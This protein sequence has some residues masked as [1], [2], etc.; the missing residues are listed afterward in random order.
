MLDAT[1]SLPL[2]LSLDGVGVAYDGREVFH[3]LS[4]RIPPGQVT[5]L[6]GPNG[7]GKSTALKAMRRVLPLSRGQIRL[8]QRPLSDWPAK[9]LA[10]EMAMLSQSPE[11]PEE[12]T[13]GD[14]VTLGR[15][16]HRPAFSG[17]RPAD[18]EAVGA[19][20]GATDTAH[21]IDR[22]IGTL[23]GGQ[24]QRAWLA[25]VI[26]Q[27]APV[28]LLDEP[29]NHLDIGHALET[30]ALVRRLSRE[31]GRTVIVV[32]HDL[33]LAARFADNIVFL[34]AG[35]IVAEGP[36]ESVFSQAVVRETFRIDCEIREDGPERRPYC[37]ALKPARS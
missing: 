3:S 32:L 25:M 13:V 7:C 23:S 4:L 22:A 19:A 6:C 35:R 34:R 27:E 15:Y 5:A 8:L 1:T 9:E 31:Q 29:T 24:Q 33:N 30:L 21:L 11:A 37:L 20:L 12:M 36:V 28:V 2:S 16:A 10:R 14:L 26:A 17:L 18:R